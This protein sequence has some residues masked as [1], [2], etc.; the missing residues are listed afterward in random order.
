MD[1]FTRNIWLLG[2]SQLHGIAADHYR[3]NSETVLP[4]ELGKM[5]TEDD[6]KRKL[7]DND[8]RVQLHSLISSLPPAELD[9]IR[10]RFAAELSYREIGAILNR[11]ED[12]VRK[13]VSRLLEKIRKQIED[14]N[15]NE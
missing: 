5:K 15:G 3:A 8:E 1:A 4:I 14:N 2:C 9:L 10:L 6:L 13:A 7:I 11:S 12:A